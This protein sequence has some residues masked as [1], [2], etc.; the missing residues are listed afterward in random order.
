MNV[1][2]CVGVCPL[3]IWCIHLIGFGKQNSAVCTIKWAWVYSCSLSLSCASQNISQLKY[4][5]NN[6]FIWYNFHVTLYRCATFLNNSQHF[7]EMHSISLTQLR[8]QMVR[9][10][11]S[12]NHDTVIWIIPISLSSNRDANTHFLFDWINL[13]WSMVITILF[14]QT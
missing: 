5:M 11:R 6:R 3:F 2:K 14:N 8:E 4:W 9:D 1:D 7:V 13:K 12:L 10:M